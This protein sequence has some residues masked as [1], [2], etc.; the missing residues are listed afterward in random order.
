MQNSS[1]GSTFEEK[2]I[3][4]NF[5]NSVPKKYL[6]NVVPI[7]QYSEFETMSFEEPVGMVKAYEEKLQSLKRKKMKSKINSNKSMMKVV[8]TEEDVE[9]TMKEIKRMRKRKRLR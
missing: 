8:D 7:K 1:L 3:K 9:G 6:P 4:R 2:V 5:L